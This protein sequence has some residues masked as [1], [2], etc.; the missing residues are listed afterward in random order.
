MM[1]GLTKDP[2]SDLGLRWGE[3]GNIKIEVLSVMG[4]WFLKLSLRDKEPTLAY[5]PLND[6]PI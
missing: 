6:H 1:Q 4:L 3:V 5:F 2:V